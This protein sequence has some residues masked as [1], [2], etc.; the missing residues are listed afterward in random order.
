MA[1]QPHRVRYLKV[2]R[3]ISS[4]TVVTTVET[5]V[6]APLVQLEAFA[7]HHVPAIMAGSLDW[8]ALAQ[9]GPP[10][11][12]PRCEAEVRR[13]I[14]SMAGPSLA[15]EYNYVIAADQRL[16]GECSL[17]AIDYRNRVAQVGICIW[18][19]T[20]RGQGY[21]TSAVHQLATWASDYLGLRR[22]EAWIT[23]NNQ[24]SLALFERH[25]FIREGVLR[26]R[27]LAAGEWDDI[28]VL[29]R[30]LPERI[31]EPTECR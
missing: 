9:S 24:P 14:A 5:P 22:L 31:T 19:P 10:Y 30:L 18:E 11:W 21:G 23:P 6:S 13:K 20:D 15:S 27:Y 29:G 1:V 12:R 17:H 8:P 16:L 4:V 7:E 28:V 26:Q 3:L 2:Y 25:G